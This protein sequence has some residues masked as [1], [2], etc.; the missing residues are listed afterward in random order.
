MRR[1]KKSIEELLTDG[2]VIDRAIRVGVRDALLRHQKLG[3]PIVVLR[4]GKVVLVPPERI[5]EE[6]E[7]SGNGPDATA[8]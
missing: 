6:L 8:R 5:T 2:A 7:R 1:L 3:Q 4:D